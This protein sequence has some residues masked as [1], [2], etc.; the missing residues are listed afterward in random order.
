MSFRNNK[1]KFGEEVGIRDSG[2]TGI[3][4]MIQFGGGEIPHKY[5]LDCSPG[6][7]GHYNWVE[8]RDESGR[9]KLYAANW[10]EEDKLKKRR[11]RAN[12]RK[13]ETPK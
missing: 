7:L 11:K 12:G 13:M 3:I 4:I 1:F 2:Y 6:A 10:F 5:L 8:L 9:P